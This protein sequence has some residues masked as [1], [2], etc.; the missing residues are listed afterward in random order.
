MRASRRQFTIG[1]FMIAIAILAV[2]LA[3]PAPAGL[4]LVLAFIVVAIGMM[5][6]VVVIAI[7][8]CWLVITPLFHFLEPADSM[9]S[10]DTT[11]EIP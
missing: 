10:V 11:D 3:N 4:L 6:I 8:A 9:R 1:G 2:C 5:I 7:L